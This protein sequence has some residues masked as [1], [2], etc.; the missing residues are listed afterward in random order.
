MQMDSEW[1][2]RRTVELGLSYA[3]IADRLGRAENAVGRIYDGK[4]RL[5]IDH[6]PVLA[7]MLQVPVLEIL[8]RAGLWETAPMIVLAPVLSSVSAGRFADMVA[9]AAPPGDEGL[10]A[11]YVEYQRNTLFATRV[12]GDSMNRVAPE[13]SL[14]IVDY[15]IKA[16]RDGDLAVFRHNAA[17]TFKRYR[18]VGGEKWLEPDSTNPAHHRILPGDGDEIEVIGKVVEIRPGYSSR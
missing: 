14:I 15:S 2:K 1:F 7:E 5:R 4:V 17:A 18:S 12:A 11:V 9:G 16:I 10:G 3:D 13:G 8:Y 6:V